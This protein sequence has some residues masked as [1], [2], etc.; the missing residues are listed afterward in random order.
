MKR[1]DAAL[2]RQAYAL[3]TPCETS[4]APK[5]MYIEYDGTGV[6]IRRA[7]L[8]GRKGKQADGSARTREVKLD[9]I[10]TQTAFD[11]EGQPMHDPLQ[12]H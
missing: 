6:P 11:E 12:P 7:E 5:L 8:R 3:Q 4:G 2:L 1:Q 9:C 10:F